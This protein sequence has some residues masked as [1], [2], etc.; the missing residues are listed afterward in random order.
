MTQ[1]L[2]EAVYSRGFTY[3]MTALLAAVPVWV[4]CAIFHQHIEVR[5]L[6][7]ISSL[8]LLAVALFWRNESK[9]TL[10]FHPE[11]LVLLE[12]RHQRTMR[13]ESIRE[14]R[15]SAS[16]PRGSGL[17]GLMLSAL[18]RRLRGSRPEVD[19]VSVSIRCVL[20]GDGEPPLLLTSA[21][22]GAGEVVSRIIQRI[23]PR[24]VEESLANLRDIGRVE[25]GPIAVTTN[26]IVGGERVIRFTEMASCGIQS[27]KFLAKRRDAWVNTIQVPVASIP[28]AFVL[29]DLLRRLDVPNIQDSRLTFATRGG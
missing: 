22:R 3:R 1:S 20:I 4:G 9:R 2:P 24:L 18:A 14:V 16:Q 6:W 28:N 5:V 12:G 26:S 11:G 10:A 17:L 13:W 25:F 7:G 15:Y 29:L 19:E 23:N 8:T 27:G 21:W